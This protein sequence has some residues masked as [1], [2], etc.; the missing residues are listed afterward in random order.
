M[1]SRRS[2]QRRQASANVRVVADVPLGGYQAAPS[3]NGLRRFRMPEARTVVP[4][5]DG[6]RAAGSEHALQFGQTRDGNIR[7]LQDKA[8]ED[9]VEGLI[10]KLSR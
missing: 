2:K 9:M 7:M 1:E 6:N 5:D 4:S 10:A 8:D 3:G